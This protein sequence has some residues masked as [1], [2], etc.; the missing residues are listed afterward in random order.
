MYLLIKTLLLGTHRFLAQPFKHTPRAGRSS[1]RLLGSR[2][3]PLRMAHN[4]LTTFDANNT[5]IRTC[6]NCGVLRTDL[7]ALRVNGIFPACPNSP[8]AAPPAPGNSCL[9]WHFILHLILN[10]CASLVVFVV[11]TLHTALYDC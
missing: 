3:V 8:P 2:G 10:D 5:P 7:D 4:F 9:R 11:I 6:S 1:V